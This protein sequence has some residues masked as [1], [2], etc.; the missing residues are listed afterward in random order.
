LTKGIYP[1]VERD[2]P[3]SIGNQ[4]SFVKHKIGEYSRNYG[5]KLKKAKVLLKAS[6]EKELKNVSGVLDAHSVP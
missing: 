1:V 2:L 3:N 5:A 4:W 6:I